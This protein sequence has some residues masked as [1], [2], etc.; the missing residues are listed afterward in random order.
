MGNLFLFQTLFLFCFVQIFVNKFLIPFFSLLCVVI[1]KPYSLFARP[2]C[3]DVRSSTKI[4]RFFDSILCERSQREICKLMVHFMHSLALKLEKYPQFQS[5][6]TSVTLAKLSQNRITQQPPLEA[7]PGTFMATSVMFSCH[8]ISPC[9]REC[10]F[11]TLD[12]QFHQPK[13]VW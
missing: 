11:A 12:R 10:A 7:I 8:P 9:S 4:I 6:F 5:N 13:G 2:F 3:A 1:R